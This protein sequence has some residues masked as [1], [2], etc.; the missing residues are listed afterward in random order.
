LAEVSRMLV[1]RAR[2]RGLSLEIESEGEIPATIAADRRRLLQVLLNLAGNALKFTAQGSVR[3]TMSW[4]DERLRFEV[5]DSGPGIAKSEQAN[6]FQSFSQGELGRR[7]G[8]G[9]GLGLHISRQI[10]RAMGGDITLESE[11]GQ[12]ATFT[13]EVDAPE[14]LSEPEQAR[15]RR[16][17]RAPQDHGLLPMLVVDDRA[18]NREVLCELLRVIGFEAE[19][20]ESGE[21]ALAYLEK[22]RPSLVWLDVKMGGMDGTEVV[23]RIRDRE[24]R[25]GTPRLP[26]VVITA[27]IIDL[28]SERA[29]RLGFDAW[30]PKPFR[31]DAVLAAIDRL[32]PVKLVVY[33]SAPEPPSS[34]LADTPETF[35]VDSLGDAERGQL[36]ELLTLGDVFSAAEW[37]KKRGPKASTLVAEI[38]SFRTDALLARLKRSG[39]VSSAAASVGPRQS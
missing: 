25:E 37:A 18:T 4:H 11:V 14:S 19:Q 9:T 35:D 20:A 1:E 39:S 24:R 33:P 7:S 36:I 30:V 28:D 29:E 12:G 17:Q 26:V 13:V 16:T 34:A 15:E 6:L 31:T 32:L 10:A 23:K 2:T 22:K 5:E 38:A 8:E 21:A 27:S 3:I